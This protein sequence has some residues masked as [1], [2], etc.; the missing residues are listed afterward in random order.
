MNNMFGSDSESESEEEE[1]S[2]K[3]KHDLVSVDVDELGNI[4]SIQDLLAD[5]DEPEEIFKLKNRVVK[6]F[7][8]QIL[9]FRTEEMNIQI[10]AAQDSEQGDV[11]EWENIEDN[12]FGET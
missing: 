7:V 1:K 2:N 6:S 9:K 4:T 8:R 3:K 12:G 10:G 11:Y 5:E